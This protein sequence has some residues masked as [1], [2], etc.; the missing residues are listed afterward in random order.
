MLRIRDEMEVAAAANGQQWP[1][2]ENRNV[3]AEYRLL[4]PELKLK[5]GR[6]GRQDWF[7]WMRCV[8]KGKPKQAGMKRK[9]NA[10][11]VYAL[12]QERNARVF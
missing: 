10:S 2:M 1:N 5:V 8:T 4:K 3:Q 11:L 7:E 6:R 9:L 12:W